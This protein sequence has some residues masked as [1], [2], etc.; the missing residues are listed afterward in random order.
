MDD[1][2]SLWSFRSIPYG[3]LPHLIGAGGKKAPQVQRF[4]H[5]HYDLWQSRFRPQFLALFFDLGFSFESGQ[6][7]LERD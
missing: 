1:T 6:A 7:F 5:G 3:P 2:G 4:P